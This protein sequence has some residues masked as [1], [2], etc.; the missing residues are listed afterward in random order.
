MAKIII[1]PFQGAPR[2]HDAEIQLYNLQSYVGGYIEACGPVDLRS[3]GIELLA[4]E[5]GLLK[6]LPVN[7][8]LFPFFFVG[9]LVMVGVSGESFVGLTDE[10]IAFAKHW[11]RSLDN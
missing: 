8:N 4:D 11:L 9:N 1:I 2:I 6:Q 3:H 10:Q 7:P 5:E